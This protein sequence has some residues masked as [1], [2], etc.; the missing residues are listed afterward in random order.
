[1][2]YLQHFTLVLLCMFLST[3]YALAKQAG[4]VLLPT[5]IVL[6]PKDRN[7]TVTVK[8]NGDATGAYRIELVDMEMPE[9][10]ALKEIAGKKPAPF[11]A[12]PFLRISPRQMVLNPGEN[13]NIRI[14]VRRSRGMEAGEYRSHLKV[15][16]IDDN[17]STEQN[18]P[19]P[20]N[21]VVIQVKPRFSLVIP[22][23]IREG[24][25]HAD[26]SLL[27]PVLRQENHRPVLD[28]TI[29]RDGNSS[30]IGDLDVTHIAPNG[31]QVQLQHYAGIAVYR[32]TAKRHISIPLEVPKGVT[33][34]G[35]KLL[36][37]YNTQ[38]KEHPKTLAEAFLPL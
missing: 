36:I 21:N 9:K 24:K 16:L 11:S 4:I 34:Q 23:I 1:M 29:K 15:K 5:R 7:V 12:K 17:V 27:S 10:G 33:L 30:A 19:A 3:S 37:R 2:R 22:L 20:N 35:G 14:L 18:T 25:T 38:E 6:E 32:P 13:Q 31:K 28:L 26:L 8:N